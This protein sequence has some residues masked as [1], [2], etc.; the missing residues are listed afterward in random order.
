MVAVDIYKRFVENARKV[1]DASNAARIEFHTSERFSDVSGRFDLVVCNIPY[2]PS[3]FGRRNSHHR[4]LQSEVWDGGDSG[5]RH[6]ET[7][8]NEAPRHLAPGG[9]LL[10]GVDPQFVRRSAT[11]SL[12]EGIPGLTLEA[13]VKTLTSPSEVYAI[14][15]NAY[16]TTN[17][18]HGATYG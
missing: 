14:Q 1:A 2:I 17:H 13:I 6:I 12:V 9:R 11:L 16:C 8:L 10:L 18:P 5:C 7:V 15:A 4:N 3:S